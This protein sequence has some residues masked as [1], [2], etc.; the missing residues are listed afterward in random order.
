M[1]GGKCFALTS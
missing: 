1:D